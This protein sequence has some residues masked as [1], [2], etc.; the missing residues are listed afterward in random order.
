MNNKLISILNACGKETKVFKTSDGTEVLMMAYGGRVLGLFSSGSDDNFYW[1]NTALETE[2]KAKAFF[3][4]GEFCHT[5]GDRTWMAPEIDFFM[6][7][8]PNRDIYDQPRSLDPGNYK[9]VEE[10]GKLKLVNNFKLTVSRTKEVVDL[11][12]TKYLGD[13]PNPLRHQRGFDLDGIEYAGYTQFA[14]LEML[15]DCNKACV[16]LW[17]LV[18]MPFGGDLI[19]PTYGKADAKVYFGDIQDKVT[20]KDG[21]IVFKMDLAGEHKIGVRATATAGRVGYIYDTGKNGKWGVIIRNFIVNP[22][23][24]YIDVP[25]QDID[26]FGYSTQACNVNSGLGQFNELEYHIPAIGKGTGRS[27]CDDAAQV[28]AFRGSKEKMESVVKTL[29]TSV[30]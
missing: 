29:L 14:T 15:S 27:K 11:K 23:G 24:E 12:I 7:Q 28:W 2:E 19:I 17:N 18:Q 21:L 22:S 8:F 1:T 26:E 16:G 20:S 4:S 9:F 13:A 6:P 5:G 3:G 25:W 10:D 30:Y